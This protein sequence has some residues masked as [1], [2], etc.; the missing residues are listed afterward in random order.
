MTLEE[1]AD[2]FEG[3]HQSGEHYRAR[4]P[5]HGSTSGTLSIAEGEEGK[6]LVRC[7]AGCELGAILACV[8]LRV[9]DLF[10][11]E[12]GRAVPLQ[13]TPYASDPQADRI[14]A[15]LKR[16]AELC[17]IDPG[18]LCEARFGRFGDLLPRE[19]DRLRARVMLRLRGTPWT[20]RT[21]EDTALAKEWDYEEIREHARCLTLDDEMRVIGRVFSERVV[22]IIEENDAAA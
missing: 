18:A 11:Q 7:F 15:D 4:C 17:E 19:L 6:L 8:G 9:S 2:R 21:L 14:A 16:Q 12:E 10:P 20:A 22:R 3:V 13:P 5:A 1:L